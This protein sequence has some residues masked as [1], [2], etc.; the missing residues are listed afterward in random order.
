MTADTPAAL[1]ET[2]LASAR[3]KIKWGVMNLILDP[4]QD[5]AR[6]ATAAFVAL[7]TWYAANSAVRRLSAI[8]EAQRLRVVVTLEPTHDGDDIYPAWLANGNEWAQE[9]QSRLGGPVQLEVLDEPA[10]A[11]FAS[12]VDGVLVAELFWRDSTHTA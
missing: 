11:E 5:D 4:A 1:A 9:L 7:A 8:S 3:L 12:G 2:L 10:F 6:P